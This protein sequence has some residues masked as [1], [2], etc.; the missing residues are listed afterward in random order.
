MPRAVSNAHESL[1]RVSGT[2]PMGNARSILA[3]CAMPGCGGDP[4]TGRSGPA[5]RSR[6]PI[7]EYTKPGDD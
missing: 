4:A 2:L 6:S 1:L 5:V 7:P 3:L